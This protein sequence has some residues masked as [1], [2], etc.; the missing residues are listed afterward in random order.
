MPERFIRYIVMRYNARTTDEFLFKE[1]EE[2]QAVRKFRGKG[3]HGG[4]IRVDLRMR[5]DD[6]SSYCLKTDYVPDPTEESLTATA[7][8]LWEGDKR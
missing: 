1:G 7:K 3:L 5:V 4:G 8:A 2:K 6:Y